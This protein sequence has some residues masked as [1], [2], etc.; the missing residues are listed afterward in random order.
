[1]QT[2]CRQPL[3]AVVRIGLL[4]S[5][6]LPLRVIDKWSTRCSFEGV[7]S[8][9]MVALHASKDGKRRGMG[10][11]GKGEFPCQMSQRARVI[12][13]LWLPCG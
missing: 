5:P 1:M 2:A 8:Q 9:A 4:P 7:Q 13:A 10:S 3:L 6:C 12:H 11:S